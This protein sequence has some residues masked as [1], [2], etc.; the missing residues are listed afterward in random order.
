MLEPA[1]RRYVGVFHG[2]LMV[3]AKLLAAAIF[4]PLPD[5]AAGG[6][7]PRVERLLRTAALD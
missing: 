2:S 3:R 6:A 4:R 5:T 1:T 7:L